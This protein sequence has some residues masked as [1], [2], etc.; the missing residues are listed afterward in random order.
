MESDQ[1]CVSPTVFDRVQLFFAFF[2]FFFNLSCTSWD[3][4]SIFPSKG[5]ALFLVE[6]FTLLSFF[7]L[8]SKKKRNRCASIRGRERV[9]EREVETE[10]TRARKTDRQEVSTENKPEEQDQQ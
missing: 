1:C 6:A 5:V 10:G 7:V 2:F 3:E 4:T 9:E 8:E